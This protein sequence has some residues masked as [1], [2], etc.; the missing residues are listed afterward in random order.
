[1]STHLTYD[2]THKPTVLRQ[3][4]GGRQ[5]GVLHGGVVGIK[6]KIINQF[7]NVLSDYI[8]NDDTMLLV[9][10]RERR[11]TIKYSKNE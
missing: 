8:Q 2:I 1:M 9:T 5:T 3:T 7:R 6:T 4:L 11:K 10:N